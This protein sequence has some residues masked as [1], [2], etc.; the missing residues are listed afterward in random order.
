M[1]GRRKRKRRVTAQEVE[2]LHVNI[3][4]LWAE[5]QGGAV[6]EFYIAM[7]AYLADLMAGLGG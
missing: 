2:Q 5:T 1:P 4:R 3:S 7:S 6:W